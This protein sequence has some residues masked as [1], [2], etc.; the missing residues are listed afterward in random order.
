MDEIQ[1]LKASVDRYWLG[2]QLDVLPA[3]HDL[4]LSLQRDTS[5]AIICPQARSNSDISFKIR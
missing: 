2:I 5:A 4:K 1:R 3:G